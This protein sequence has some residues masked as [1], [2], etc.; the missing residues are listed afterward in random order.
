MRTCALPDCC[1][2]V[3][4]ACLLPCLIT[5]VGVTV[6]TIV[7]AGIGLQVGPDFRTG[8]ARKLK[9]IEEVNSH[10]VHI[11]LPLVHSA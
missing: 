9:S 7:I 1:F 5:L 8:A 11:L 4:I 2:S 3:V 6:V 10:L